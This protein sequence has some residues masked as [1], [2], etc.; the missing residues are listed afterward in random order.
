MASHEERDFLRS[1]KGYMGPNLWK[2]DVSLPLLA[3]DAAW[4]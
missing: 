4:R 3:D 1:I 2:P